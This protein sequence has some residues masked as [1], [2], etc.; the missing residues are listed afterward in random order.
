MANRTSLDGKDAYP[1][2]PAQISLEA[3]DL[4]RKQDASE[5]QFDASTPTSTRPRSLLN[6]T[7][8]MNLNAVELP[9]GLCPL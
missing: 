6:L 5:L 4:T 1:P 3:T 2:G 7:E 8:D 9:S